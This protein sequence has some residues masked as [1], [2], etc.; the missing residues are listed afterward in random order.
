MDT[1]IPLPAISWEVSEIF[2]PG[3]CGTTECT[4]SVLF[5]HELQMHNQRMS[6]CNYVA[7]WLITHSRNTL[8]M[9]Y[10]SGL[11]LTFFPAVI[12]TS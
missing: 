7:A 3:K 5:S 9:K 6:Y 12:K 10:T 8:Q 1:E 2:I 4:Y 11:L